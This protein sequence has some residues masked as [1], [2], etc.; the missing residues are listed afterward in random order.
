[1]YLEDQE[2]K[3]VQLNGQQKK[4]IYLMRQKNTNLFTDSQISAGN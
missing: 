4:I 3:L 1:M 2:E